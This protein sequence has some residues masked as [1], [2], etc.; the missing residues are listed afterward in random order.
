MT[1]AL[2]KLT[3]LD[4]TQVMAG[5]FCCQLLADHGARVT[6]VEPIGT[7]D[8]SRYAMGFPMR[9]EDNASFLAVNRNK[10]SVALDLKTEAGRQV[11]YRLVH[12]ADIVVENFRPGVT[13]RLG[14]D[15]ETLRE[16]NPRIIYASI[17]GFGQT[18]PYAS[19]AGYDLIA[20][21]MSGVM[22]VTGEADGNPVKC[23]IPIG[24]LGAGLFATLGILSA[25]IAR[26]QTGTGQ[27]I[28]VSL[29]ESALALSVWESTELWTT[30]QVP[31][32]YGSAHRLSAPYQ[33]LRTGDGYI[34]VGANNQRLWERFCGAIG[35]EDLREDPRFAT[36]ADRMAGIS[37]LVAEIEST[38]VGRTTDDWM[39]AL[40]DAGV[41]CGPIR[42][43]AEVFEDPHT[44]ARDMMVEMDHPVEGTVRGLGIPVKMSDTPGSVRRAAP[45]LGEHTDEVLA[46]HGYDDDEITK[47]RSE[48]AIG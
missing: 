44:L 20:Q 46:R 45:L 22:S 26:Q 3:V 34:T 32:R 40:D 9:G 25:Y 7:G 11:F 41:P 28:D 38:M 5:P 6:K 47:L 35:R 48:G 1:L 18:G 33:S 2:E 24:D 29:Y 23:G 12:D 30:G 13:A 16:V 4:L 39:R 19:R 36:N 17:S 10:D 15:Y 14:V 43:Y 8:A 42:D 31:A 27:H 21:A 37:E